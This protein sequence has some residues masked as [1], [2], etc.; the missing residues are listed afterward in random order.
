MP[1]TNPIRPT[2]ESTRTLARSLIKAAQFGSLGVIDPQSQAPMVTR[3]AVG[4]DRTGAPILLIS[5]LSQHT[6]ALKQNPACSLLVGE[7]AAHGDPLLHPR[8]TLQCQAGFIDRHSDSHATLR[9]LYLPSHPKSK[10][11]IDFADFGFVVLN[12]KA[13]FLNGGFGKAFALTPADILT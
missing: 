9:D 5:T 7:P 3:V 12:I 4:T 11:Y 8:L 10:L 6:K 1:K 13:G 2:D